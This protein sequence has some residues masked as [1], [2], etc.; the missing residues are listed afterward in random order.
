MKSPASAVISRVKGLV[1]ALFALYWVFVVALLVAA[2]PVFDQLLNQQV[3]V[4]GDSRPAELA[5]VIVLTSLF[6]LFLV[7]IIRGWRWTFWLI[8]V[9]FLVGILRVPTAAL[10]LAGKVSTEAPAWYVGLT[11]VVGLIQFC[12]ALVMLLGYR[13]AGIWAD[14]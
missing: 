13:R 8:L 5:T 12:I 10:E 2:R 1:L 6:S 4:S 9:V 7:G 11:A 3:R 14:I